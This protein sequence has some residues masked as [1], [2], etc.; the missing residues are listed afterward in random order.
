LQ[1]GS[2]GQ[3]LLCQVARRIGSRG[4]AGLTE[5]GQQ[6]RAAVI[7]EFILRRIRHAATIT[8]DGLDQRMTTATAEA[9]IVRVIKTAVWTLHRL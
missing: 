6:G 2:R 7:A 9:C 8:V 1:C 4:I 5:D 3:Y